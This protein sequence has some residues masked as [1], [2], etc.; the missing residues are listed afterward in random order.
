MSGSIPLAL[1]VTR[2]IGIGTV[3]FGFALFQGRDRRPRGVDQLLRGSGEVRS[4][5]AVGS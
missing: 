4:P 5:V 2:S 3:A 1:D